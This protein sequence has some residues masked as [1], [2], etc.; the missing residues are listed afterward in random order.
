MSHGNHPNHAAGRQ[1]R[2]SDEDSEMGDGIRRNYVNV[3]V[4]PPPPAPP[5]PNYQQQQQ[6]DQNCQQQQQQRQAHE[7]IEVRLNESYFSNERR[8]LVNLLANCRQKFASL[9]LFNPVQNQSIKEQQQQSWNENVS[10][11]SAFLFTIFLRR[12]GERESFF[13][14]PCHLALREWCEIAPASNVFLRGHRSGA[15]KRAWRVVLFPAAGTSTSITTTT[16]SLTTAATKPR[17]GKIW[18]NFGREMAKKKSERS[19]DQP[20]RGVQLELGA[21]RATS[22]QELYVSGAGL[23]RGLFRVC[24]AHVVVGRLC[25]RAPRSTGALICLPAKPRGRSRH[26]NSNWSNSSICALGR[27]EPARARWRARQGLTLRFDQR[28][29]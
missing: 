6:V 9:Q 23:E 7:T 17:R 21:V 20:T 5:R 8:A 1:Q 13:G 25:W 4:Q 22:K 3:R 18:V 16:T 15:S 27:L 26:L 28:H 24:G 14:I 10:P 11:V 2:S 29:H 19:I 12:C